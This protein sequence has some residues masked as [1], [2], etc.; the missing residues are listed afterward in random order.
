MK[1]RFRAMSN[2]IAHAHLASAK[3]LLEK[4]AVAPVQNLPEAKS[5][6]EQLAKI[7]DDVIQAIEATIPPK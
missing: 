4:L 6:V 7:L 5:A 1:G 2:E 3:G